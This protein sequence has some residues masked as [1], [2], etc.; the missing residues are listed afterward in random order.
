MLNVE[1]QEGQAPPLAE[2]VPLDGLF[3]HSP[4]RRET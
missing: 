1:D 3:E 2:P 4:G